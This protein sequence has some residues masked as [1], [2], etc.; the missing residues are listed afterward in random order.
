MATG[1]GPLRI[2]IEDFIEGF[3]LSDKIH[4]WI[5]DEGEKQKNGSLGN[6]WHII[7]EQLGVEGKLPAV[8]SPNTPQ[9]VLGLAAA[10]PM[11]LGAVIGLGFSFVSVLI[12]PI[13]FLAQYQVNKRWSAYRI[14]PRQAAQLLK[15]WPEKSS[16]WLD[17]LTD[18]GVNE[19]NLNGL[20]ALNRQYLNA[21]QYVALWRR[22][23]LSNTE[24]DNKLLQLNFQDTDIE[25]LKQITEVIPTPNDLIL[26]AVREAF[27]DEFSRR[28]GHDENLPAEFV[29]WAKKQGLS[30]DWSKRY[31]RAHWQ[32]PSP[33]QVFEMLHRLRPGTTD[34]P[35]SGDDVDFYLR[36]ADYAPFWRDRLKEIS[37]NPFTRVDVRRMYKTGVLDEAGVMTAYLDLGFDQAK[38]EA[39]TQFTIA[40][41]AE[42]ETGIIR[43]SVLSAY[44]DGMIDR[45]T[46]ARMLAKGGYDV[47]TVAFYL[48]NIDF[49][50]SLEIQQ[51][52]LSNIRKRY[53]EG[54]LDEATVNAEINQLNLPAERVSAMLELWGTERENQIALLTI[55]QMETLLE[56]GIV[57]EADYRRVAVRRGYTDETIGWTLQ[58]IALE[59][60]EKAQ[61]T[62]EK[63][64]ADNE[65]LQKSR[66]VSQYQ[67]DKAEIDL[68]IAQ[69]RAEITDIDVALHGEISD[70]DSIS[71]LARKDEL[72]SF[73]AQMN[74][75]K[76]QLRFDTQTSLDNLAG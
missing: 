48:D 34:N 41:E 35:I 3:K 40:Y 15:L 8:V 54:L 25:R 24:L 21:L 72:K 1:K 37:Y 71:L 55:T 73:I 9:A 38:A 51:I 27:D 14:E 65:R 26:M 17:M 62:A 49:R 59:A 68:S 52:K 32:L 75:V 44:G 47:T 33:Q 61:T 53:V 42:E 10:I 30:E 5:N 66:T 58:R 50:E 7:M 2:A 12:Q 46:A 20:Q 63:A 67:K 70:D 11:L 28:F 22:G 43:S 39:M 74:V 29:E 57:E 4:R 69:A 23:Q 45:A 18:L 19:S 56:K 6:A 64:E 36:A 31:W 76:A 13:A 60:S 16:E